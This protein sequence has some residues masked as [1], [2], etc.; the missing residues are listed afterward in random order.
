MNDPS[1]HHESGNPGLEPTDA[2]RGEDRPSRSQIKREHQALQV[3]AEQLAALPRAQLE[4]L[5]LGEATWVA[6][7]ETAR[8]KDQRALRRHYKRI[9]NCLAREDTEPLRA[10]L[11]QREAQ[12]QASAARQ[13]RVE[14]WRAR[15]IAEGDPALSELIDAYPG[16]DRQRLRTLVRAAQKDQ[17]RGRPDASRR[18]F[19]HL[20]AIL[21]AAA[22]SD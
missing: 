18:L 19:R 1:A 15:L 5:S 7:D 4:A 9:A 11:A 21:D 10:L 8:I 17:A 20:R 3:L 16:V 22:G 12:A 2:P 14:R 13:H 6:L